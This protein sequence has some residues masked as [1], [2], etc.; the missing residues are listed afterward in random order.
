VKGE[1][2]RRDQPSF[3]IQGLKEMCNPRDPLYRL[4]NMIPWDQVESW[5]EDEY[6]IDGRPAK[7]VRL[8]VSLL[9]LKRLYNLGDETVVQEWVQNPYMQYFSGETEFQWE[10]PCEPSDLVHFRNRI[11]EEGVKKILK[12][13]IDLHGKDAQEAE[14]VIDTTVQEKNITFPT[15]VKLHRKI[16]SQCVRIAKAEGMPLRQTY[17]RTVKHLVYLQRGRNNIR[18]KKAALKAGRRLKTI[19]GR[20]L[21]ELQRKLPPERLSDYE[22]KLAIF[23]KIL[24]QQRDSK[25][26][27]YSIHEPHVYCVAKGKDHKKYEFGSKV[28]IARTKRSGIIVGALNIEKNQYDGH[29]LSAAL[30]QIEGLRGSRP[31]VAITDQ[32]YRGKKHYGE[33]VIVNARD[34]RRQKTAYRRRKVKKQLR[35]R[36]AIEPVI[37]H[38]KS[39][40]RLSRNYLSGVFGDNI[41]VMLAAAGY[42]FKRLL[43]KLKH[44]LLDF[45]CLV[46]AGNAGQ[47]SLELDF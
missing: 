26:K 43:R 37:E 35:Q 31:T 17:T 44:F 3:M 8:M 18:T 24:S 39:G 7:P 10:L 46:F 12:L 36:S 22:Q 23:E 21:R 33:T 30:R 45:L 5:F 2:P 6:A 40:H 32:G 41:N 9:I 28:S 34:L 1:S 42:N 19:S 14:V 47:T 38:L 29:T 15:D 11:R 16:A 4:A 20:L 27:I 25:N 13:S